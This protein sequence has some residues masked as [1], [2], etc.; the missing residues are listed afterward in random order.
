MSSAD[1]VRAQ[2]GGY[3]FDTQL[4]DLQS[5][6]Q[7]KF[8]SD[9]NDFVTSALG[10]MLL[11]SVAFG[12]DSL[13]F[14]LDRRATDTYLST[15]RTRSSVARLSRQLGYKMR[16]AVASSVDL[17]VTIPSPGF[18]VT[19]PIGFRF[20][21]PN[22]LI[23]EVSQAV[24]WLASDLSRLKTVPCYE[25][26]TVTET[27]VSNGTPNQVFYLR[28]VPSDKAV[29]AG[30]VTVLVNGSPFKET[31][32]IEFDP[33]DQ[34]EIGYND[35]PPTVRFG[36]GNGAGNIP[37]AGA[38]IVVTYVASRGASGLVSSNTITSEVTPLVVA[39][40]TVSMTITNPL[41]SV[42]GSDPEDLTHAKTYAPRVF[43]SRN[44][45]VT[46]QDYEAL[47]NSFA[48]P[49]FGRVAAAQ[50]LATRSAIQDTALTSQLAIIKT[51]ADN[52]L[53]YAGQ[54]VWLTGQ[55]T[56]VAIDGTII[57][58]NTKF[59]SELL[60]GSYIRLGRDP[61]GTAYRR[62]TTITSDLLMQ[63][64][65]GPSAAITVPDSLMRP[66]RDITDAR[67]KLRDITTLTTSIVDPGV[68]PASG[69]LVDVATN[70][71]TIQDNAVTTIPDKV[72]EARG[73]LSD[74]SNI[75]TTIKTNADYSLTGAP[76]GWGGL[77]SIRIDTGVI[78]VAGTTS[79]G[80]VMYL[81]KH[82]GITLT[83]QNGGSLTS[84]VTVINSWT[85]TIVLTIISGTTTGRQITN[86]VQAN[87]IGQYLDAVWQGTGAGF[88]GLTTATALGSYGILSSAYIDITNWLN[89]IK[90]QSDT[91]NSK[92]ALL[93]SDLDGISSSATTIASGVSLIG[94]SATAGLLG[95]VRAASN[96]IAGAAATLV[97]DT[98][99]VDATTLANPA[100]SLMDNLAAIQSN[101]VSTYAT[102]AA[103]ADAIYNHV[104]LMLNGDCQINLVSV[105]ILA[106]DKAGFY[107]EPS[108]GLIRALQQYLDER[109]EV[110][111]TVSVVSGG[112]SLVKVRITARV[113]VKRSY[114]ESIVGSAAAT[115][116]E[117]LLRNR[118]F[119]S[120]L[121]LADLYNVVD[122][123][124]GVSFSNI[125]IVA[126]TTVTPDVDTGLDSD[127]N[128][129][130]GTG[131]VITK[132][133]DA[134][135][136]T[137]TTE[138]TTG[139]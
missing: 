125:Q 114:S 112:D 17:D 13:S 73:Y 26:E 1:L 109:K 64:T 128:L 97:G 119:G 75:A 122:A 39:F 58:K 98:S 99:S 6:L 2:Y 89:T 104:D 83:V 16:A 65:P 78:T 124:D 8:A 46:Q 91:L 27:F 9:Y 74:E 138:T 4:D 14:Y 31:E 29:V 66:G 53:P 127:G 44:V 134:G 12:L 56:S 90:R 37:I 47:S 88:A 79:D 72:L 100:T 11:D 81:P 84:T 67:A 76:L 69:Y 106:T 57:G 126:A 129:I 111:Q 68:A 80:D 137:V 116:I 22:S 95:S 21:G 55:A 40:Q 85:T 113:G 130:I 115:A 20:Q 45:A 139:T 59:S 19:I 23:F 96:Q 48:S 28:R 60:V 94:V 107:V 135:A 108:S 102:I 123:I 50:A 71:V 49:L 38:S 133:P 63:V 121:Y 24:T 25:G 82:H 93:S 43:K 132:D 70:A 136:I 117:G 61:V 77:A 52:V 5:R 3:D 33:T 10:I 15:A 110:T 54:E 86:Y 42:G 103:A 34:F 87:F 62:V 105:P 92:I 32:F 118:K 41:G 30:S 35:D 101:A 120:D 36:D 7:V 51:N 131:K 18:N